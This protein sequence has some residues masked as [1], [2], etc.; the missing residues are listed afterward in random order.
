MN[1][2][3]DDVHSFLRC[4]SRWIVVWR[5]RKE[6]QQWIHL[7]S[8][9]RAERRERNTT[10]ETGVCVRTHVLL[11]GMMYVAWCW[12]CMSG[13]VVCV[14][15]MVWCCV[16]GLSRE[17]RRLLRLCRPVVVEVKRLPKRMVDRLLRM[18]GPTS[19]PCIDL[20]DDHHHHHH[21]HLDPDHFGLGAL[22]PLDPLDPL[23]SQLDYWANPRKPSAQSTIQLQWMSGLPPENSSLCL[24]GSSGSGILAPQYSGQVGSHSLVGLS[25]GHNSFIP[26]VPGHIQQQQQVVPP[27]LTLQPSNVSSR[28]VLPLISNNFKATQNLPVQDGNGRLHFPLS[29]DITI[30]PIRAS[31]EPTHREL[32]ADLMK[33]LSR[34]K[35]PG[36]LGSSITRVNR[37]QARAAV[38]FSPSQALH[39]IPP[40]QPPDWERVVPLAGGEGNTLHHTLTSSSIEVIDLSSDEDEYVRVGRGRSEAAN[41]PPQLDGLD[42]YPHTGAKVPSESSEYS[43][44]GNSHWSSQQKSHCGAGR[45]GDSAINGQPTDV[46]PSPCSPLTATPAP[47][48]QGPHTKGNS[49]KRKNQEDL[50]PHHGGKTIILDISSKGVIVSE[51]LCPFTPTPTPRAS[52]TTSP[53]L[54]PTASASSD[55]GYRQQECCGA[56]EEAVMPVASL[57]GHSAMMAHTKVVSESTN[58]LKI[59]QD[60]SFKTPLQIDEH[61]SFNASQVGSQECGRLCPE[62]ALTSPA[63]DGGSSVK[64]LTSLVTKGMELFKSL[65]SKASEGAVVSPGEPVS[66]E[67]FHAAQCGAATVKRTNEVQNL[68]R[69]ECRE[70]RRS[71]LRELS[72][73][74][75]QGTRLTRRAVGHILPAHPAR[76]TL[77]PRL[78][79]NRPPYKHGTKPRREDGR[80]GRREEVAC[81]PLAIKGPAPLTTDENG[82]SAAYVQAGPKQLDTRDDLHPLSRVQHGRGGVAGPASPREWK[83]AL[84]SFPST[85][86]HSDCNFNSGGHGGKNTV[87]SEVSIQSC[88]VLENNVSGVWGNSVTNTLEYTKCGTGFKTK[89]TPTE[90]EVEKEDL[91]PGG[92]LVPGRVNGHRSEERH[93][94]GPKGKAALGAKVKLGTPWP[95]STTG[96]SVGGIKKVTNLPGPGKD[97]SSLGHTSALARPE[98]TGETAEECGA[99]LALCPLPD[100]LQHH[101][102][103][104]DT[105]PPTTPPRPHLTLLNSIRKEHSPPDNHSTILEQDPQP[106]LCPPAKPHSTNRRKRSR[107]C[108]ELINLGRDE[109]KEM[110]GTGYHPSDLVGCKDVKYLSVSSDE[111]EP[112]SHFAL[113]PASATTSAPQAKSR[114]PVL[115]SKVSREVARLLGDECKEL[116]PPRGRPPKSHR[117]KDKD[118][119]RSM[120]PLAS[121]AHST[122]NLLGKDRAPGEGGDRCSTR[123]HANTQPLV[124]VFTH[125]DTHRHLL[126][127]EVAMCVLNYELPNIH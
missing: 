39:H 25:V 11:L 77:G 112:H 18:G 26:L 69:D 118:K 106:H 94:C 105:T 48:T 38:T 83:V 35:F 43:K 73:L 63:L 41:A 71:G 122:H 70:L 97:V 24:P 10:I 110:Q 1:D 29:A 45:V 17:S 52:P 49:R 120:H 4:T 127:S 33:P 126:R 3:D 109:W 57:P 54:T 76:K 21:H 66:L 9:S 103:G 51:D 88:G 50:S 114:K 104:S 75:L 123:S 117:D 108:R 42:C 102:G 65:V 98:L 113:T 121:L 16:A 74:D 23:E 53:T 20:T 7:Y 87:F 95:T 125:R 111:D 115:S 85:L 119:W 86:E 47:C 82:N 80:G 34:K 46:L 14:M 58:S 2:D 64:F 32:E 12:C 91:F 60:I 99:Q 72:H 81:V 36:H 90:S 59:N 93:V 30:S 68:L 124:E 67:S 116:R 61:V 78:S 79:E 44:N 40:P 89:V 22:E 96:A 101:P 13:V 15:V 19:A 6:R 92:V 31:G 107:R 84:T 8:F 100:Q 62:E 56:T 27:G 55:F 28:P 37:Q 5:N